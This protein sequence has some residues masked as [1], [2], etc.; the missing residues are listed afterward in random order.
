MRR[1]SWIVLGIAAGALL[2]PGLASGGIGSHDVTVG[3]SASGGTYTPKNVSATVGSDN[4]VNWLPWN[5]TDPLGHNVKQ[6]KNLFNSG[7]PVTNDPNGFTRIL[8]AGTFGYYCTVH[9]APGVGMAG[10]IKVKPAM[11]PDPSGKPFTVIWGG[12]ETQSGNA[13]DVRYR[14]GKGKWK[15][16]K[17]GTKSFQAVFGKSGKPVS[18][19]SGT[20][21]KFQVRSK[22]A[23]TSRVSK[24]SPSLTVK[25]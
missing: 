18:I 10:A 4:E 8:S 23:G 11:N 9:G 21:Y 2:V 19:H 6:D 22:Q 15:M 7:D 20:A 16:W 12:Q 1:R 14:A 17:K 5:S 24:Y 13:F 25:P 3:D